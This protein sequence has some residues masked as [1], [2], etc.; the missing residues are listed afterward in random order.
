VAS[1]QWLDEA[2]DYIGL[3][4]FVGF[5]LWWVLFPNSVIRFYEWFHRRKIS[6]PK[7]SI[8]RIVGVLWIAL[9]LWVTLH[10][11]K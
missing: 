7:Q 3:I 8:V 6:A 9:V 11:V 10:A 5:G 4:V 2:S 1:A